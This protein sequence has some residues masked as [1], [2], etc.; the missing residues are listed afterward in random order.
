[1]GEYCVGLA[2]GP[3]TGGLQGANRSQIGRPSRIPGAAG[4]KQR[5]PTFRDV[6]VETLERSRPESSIQSLSQARVLRSMIRE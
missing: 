4:A 1:M 3:D 6:C 2:S 5:V